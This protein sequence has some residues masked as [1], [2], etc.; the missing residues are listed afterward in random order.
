VSEEREAVWDYI[1][2]LEFDR[3]GPEAVEDPLEVVKEA[4]SYG[5]V[6]R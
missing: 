6:L 2:F 4:I 5:N 3:S 1:K